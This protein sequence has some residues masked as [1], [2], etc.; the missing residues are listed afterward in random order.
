MKFL[1]DVHI[2]Y[3]V[4][5]HLRSLGYEASHVNEILDRWHT[6]DQDI[7]AYA[8]EN[9]LIVITKDSDFK[10]GF[11]INNTPKKLV[12]INLGN[13][14][15]SALIEVISGNLS[16]IQSLNASGEFMIELDQSS[17]TFIRK[18]L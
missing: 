2:S 12:K 4:V 5:R 6:K 8:D 18:K 14:S 17:A 16:A 3:K 13:I 10:N 7:C 15:T 1:C 11:L 9:D